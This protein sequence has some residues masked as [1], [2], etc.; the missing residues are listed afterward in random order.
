MFTLLRL[1]TE[2]SW[3]LS[4]GRG[5]IPLNVIISTRQLEQ[6]MSSVFR[7]FFSE[8]RELA[9]ILDAFKGSHESDVVGD[10]EFKKY[11]TGFCHQVFLT[12]RTSSMS[13][14]CQ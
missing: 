14:S 6:Y 1:S 4:G 11:P 12:N 10:K 3:S 13:S 9:P 5:E 2:G 8:E 7:C